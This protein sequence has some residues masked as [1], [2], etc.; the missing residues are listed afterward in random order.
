MNCIWTLHKIPL[1]YNSLTS[2]FTKFVG[3]DFFLW[4]YVKSTVF[5]KTSARLT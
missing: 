2:L 1:W 4:S 5:Q 3:F